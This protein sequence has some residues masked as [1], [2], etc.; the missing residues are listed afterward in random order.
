MAR[1]EQKRLFYR[2]GTNFSFKKYVTKIKQKFNVLENYNVSLNED[3]NVRQLLY[4]IS[5]P[6]KYLKTEVNICRSSHSASFKKAS[7]YLSTVISRIFP[8]NHPPSG[9]YGKR[10]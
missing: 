5:F 1:E 10:Q 6:N 8:E 4:N 9:K 2:K 3:D 7:T